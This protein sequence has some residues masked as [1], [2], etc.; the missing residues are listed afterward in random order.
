[1]DPA[2][3]PFAVM[4]LIVAPA[5][6]TNACSVL[7]MST[8]NRLA[9]A[10]DRAREL[11]KQLEASVD[12]ASLEDQR[13]MDELTAAEERA[14]LL[15]Q[16]LR[17][18]YAALAGFALAALVSLLGAILV[19]FLLGW[20]VSVLEIAAVVTGLLAVAA[21]IHGASLL[22]RE[23]RIAVQVLHDRA[24]RVRARVP[25]IG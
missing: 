18:L 21:L 5:I 10:V 4:S 17:S 20:T 11:S 22:V 23:T 15:V 6:L 7:A 25:R 9:R 13:R 2:S 1:M 24:A 14:L 16:A 3:N 8:S 12:E 19:P